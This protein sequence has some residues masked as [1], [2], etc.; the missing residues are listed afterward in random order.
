[1][2]SKPK[3]VP[4]KFKLIVA[5]VRDTEGEII[6][7]ALLDQ[8]YRVTLIA[9][10]GGFMRRGNATLLIGVEQSRV[11]GAVQLIHENSA[12]GVDPGLKR[13]T[14]FVLAVDRFE[15]I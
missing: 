15:Q 12:P 2:S 11:Q 6:S 9:S 4:Q 14:I 1:M 5:I 3:T 10:T 7:K 8:G 13:A